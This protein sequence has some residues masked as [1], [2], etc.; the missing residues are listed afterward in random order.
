[1]KLAFALIFFSSLAIAHG[2]K[3]FKGNLKGTSLPCT[4]HI[5]QIYYIDNIETPENLRAD[6]E[7]ILENDHHHSEH[8]EEFIFTIAPT[9]HS[10]IFSGLGDNQK[11]QINLI[12]KDNSVE[13]S[14]PNFF[15][16]KWWH[17]NHFHSAQCVNLKRVE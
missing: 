4:L 12:V 1:M 11:D 8:G 3:E 6:I 10:N 13:L 2:H 17:I 7:V 9:N 14:D 16:V 15:A 5:E